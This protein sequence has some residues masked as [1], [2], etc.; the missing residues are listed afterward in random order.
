MDK[1]LIEVLNTNGLL[2]FSTSLLIF[3][4][5]FYNFIIYSNDDLNLNYVKS[6]IEKVIYQI[7]KD[8]KLFNYSNSIILIF[9]KYIYIEGNENILLI[10]IGSKER[11][12]E[13]PI[14]VSGKGNSKMF[15]FY[16]DNGT[17][18]IQ[19]LSPLYI[20]LIKVR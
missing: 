16:Y 15:K 19:S 1:A 18:F 5:T 10:K 13:S 3:I 6:E 12:I 2:I 11:T 20:P 14:K 4:L 7:Y 8:I 17:I 9:N